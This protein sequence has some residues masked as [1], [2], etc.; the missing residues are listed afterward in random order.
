MALQINIVTNITLCYVA[1]NPHETVLQT[2]VD[3]LTL[4]TFTQV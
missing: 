1:K 4:E 3:K 2:N